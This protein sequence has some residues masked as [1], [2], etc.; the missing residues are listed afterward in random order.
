VF[1]SRYKLILLCQIVNNVEYGRS[2][3]FQKAAAAEVAANQTLVALTST[4]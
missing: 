4:N 2:T 1:P 3:K